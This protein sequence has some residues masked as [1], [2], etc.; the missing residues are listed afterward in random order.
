MLALGDPTRRQI[1]ELLAG[2]EKSAGEIGARFALTQPGV[3]RHLRVLREAGIVTVRPQAQQ[4]IYSLDLS[5]L[6][7]IEEWAKVTRT[8]WERRL[9]AL[10]SEME[11]RR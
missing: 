2:G 4:R 1:V 10:S 8:T 9:E 6:A 3:S 5:V 7:E 11:G